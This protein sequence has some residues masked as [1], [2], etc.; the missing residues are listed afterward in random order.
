VTLVGAGVTVHHC[1]RAADQLAADGIACR[2]IDL[3]SVKPVDAESLAAAAALTSGRLVVVE[4]HHP[5]G[6]LGSAVMET[7]TGRGNSLRITHLAV[8]DLPGSGRPANLMDAAGIDPAAITAAARSL[9]GDGVIVD[10]QP[11]PDLGWAS[12]SNVHLSGAGKCGPGER[13][14]SVP[15]PPAVHRLFSG[16][17]QRPTQR[18]RNK[19]E[20]DRR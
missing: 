14:Y 1:L 20:A 8:R 12:L 15:R 13:G 4:V 6:G 3:Y 9:H 7:I 11:H 2:V 5:E 16:M 18:A 17:A 10:A 19:D